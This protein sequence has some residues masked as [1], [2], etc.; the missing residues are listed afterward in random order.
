MFVSPFKL[1]GHLLGAELGGLQLTS[2]QVERRK[3]HFN[4]EIAV[5]MMFHN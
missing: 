4:N 2:A 1:D 3:K 5:L